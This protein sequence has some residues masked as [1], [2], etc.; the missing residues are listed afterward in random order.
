M[1][2]HEKLAPG[3]FVEEWFNGVK[4][5]FFVPELELFN[6]KSEP[7]TEKLEMSTWDFSNDG[8][9]NTVRIG[10]YRKAEAFTP[11]PFYFEFVKAGKTKAS[12][13]G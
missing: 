13:G 1:L 10:Q 11:T 5:K 4:E 8:E 2:L 3:G 6:P 9:A 7:E 12:V